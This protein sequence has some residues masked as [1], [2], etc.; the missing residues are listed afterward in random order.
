[1]KKYKRVVLYY[2]EGDQLDRVIKYLKA[3]YPMKA[4]ASQLTEMMLTRYGPFLDSMSHK[5]AR[6][7]AITCE[8]WGQLIREEWG[9][10][11]SSVSSPQTDEYVEDE[12]EIDVAQ[13][14]LN[15]MNLF[16]DGGN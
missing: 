3:T 2:E 12:E 8:G 5:Q 15:I 7:C 14:N 9:L 16:R 11:T 1:M 10:E 6:E 13:L 4:V